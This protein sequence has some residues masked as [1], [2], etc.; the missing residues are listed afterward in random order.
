[1]TEVLSGKKSHG[2]NS[3]DASK[4]NSSSSAAD[5]ENKPGDDEDAEE[6]AEEDPIETV[7]STLEQARLFIRS[8]LYGEE[9]HS[10]NAEDDERRVGEEAIRIVESK[11]YDRENAEDVRKLEALLA[12]VHIRLAAA[13]MMASFVFSL[14]LK[15]RW[16][17]LKIKSLISPLHHLPPSF[18]KLLLWSLGVFVKKRSGRIEDGVLA[19]SGDR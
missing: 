7:W 2:E 8:F 14:F 17:E 5:D 11:V 3:T 19:V 16:I 15:T 18:L 9:L 6:E 1:M 10:V 12:D 13:S 4:S